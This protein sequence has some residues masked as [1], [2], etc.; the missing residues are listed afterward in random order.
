MKRHNAITGAAHPSPRWGT[1]CR[2]L[3]ATLLAVGVALSALTLRAPSS[4]PRGRTRDENTALR[5][6][7]DVQQGGTLKKSMQEAQLLQDSREAGL[8]TD[9]HLEGRFGR[10]SDREFARAFAPEK[11]AAKAAARRSQTESYELVFPEGK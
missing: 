4:R 11:A 7:A 10:G 1:A 6:V 5:T 3:L 8:L 2:T 9:W